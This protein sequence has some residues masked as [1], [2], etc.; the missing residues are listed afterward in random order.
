MCKIIEAYNII[1]HSYQSLLFRK[2]RGTMIKKKLAIGGAQEPIAT[3]NIERSNLQERFVTVDNAKLFCRTIG[4]GK[5]LIVLHGGPGLAQDYLLP[6]LYK[7]AENN[8]VIFYDQRG[9]GQSTGEINANTMNIETFVADLDAIR[10]TFKFKKI[11]VLGHS[12]GGFLAMHYAIAHPER[13]EKLILSNSLPASSEEFALFL[14]EWMRRMAPYQKELDAIRQ[15]KEFAEGN[16]DTIAKRHRLI[17]RTYCYKPEKANL[18]NLYKSQIASINDT[19]V[20][21]ICRK[22][23]FEKSFDFHKSLKLVKMPT[24]I[25]HGDVDP[26][27]PTTAQKTHES[28]SGSKYILMKNCGHFPYVEDPDVYFKHLKTFLNHK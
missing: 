19:K 28:I 4:K 26:I 6:E 10:D 25:L 21:D 1:L 13:V 11:I 27:P 14:Q 16:S 18:L 23:I 8:F 22:N 2:T 24:L 7:L 5:P 17:F 20:Y 9:C 3:P 12:W 15:S